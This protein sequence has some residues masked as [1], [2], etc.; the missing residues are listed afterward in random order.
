M[1]VR[2]SEPSDAERHRKRDALFHDVGEAR[3][4]CQRK[5]LHQA[6]ELGESVALTLVGASWDLAVAG[7]G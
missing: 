1:R 7:L 5:A 4:S 3:A 2:E 6:R